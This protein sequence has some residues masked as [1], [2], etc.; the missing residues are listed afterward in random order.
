MTE[1][2]GILEIMQ[3]INDDIN[4]LSEIIKEDSK[5]LPD[6]HAVNRISND[7]NSIKYLQD[8]LKFY[9]SILL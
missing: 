1:K 8:K 5:N 4:N 3:T 6:I 7:I 2:L 9:T